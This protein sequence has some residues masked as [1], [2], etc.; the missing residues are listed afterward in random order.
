[1]SP[2]I[3]LNSP[4]RRLPLALERRQVLFIDGIRYSVGMVE[5]A[6]NRL[7]ETLKAAV[8]DRSR[9]RDTTTPEGLQS[10]QLEVGHQITSALLD[11]WTVVDF[12]TQAVAL[13]ISVDADDSTLHRLEHEG[14]A[15]AVPGCRV[16]EL[17]RRAQ[18]LISR[19]PSVPR[20][21]ELRIA[22]GVPAPALEAWLLLGVDPQC[23]EAAWKIRMAAERH[24][25]ERRRLKERL[26]GTATDP[27]VVVAEREARR[28]AA[29]LPE[30]ERAFPGGFGSLARGVRR[31]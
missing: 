14:K 16:C 2:I 1:M 17:Q 21:S 23:T 6:F 31:W 24:W 20:R 11:A 25:N 19:L 28:V 8:L 29:M 27:P 15:T 5:L 22:V 9:Q 3:G 10:F 4:L 18:E 30:L 12:R 13:A 7:S 26:Y